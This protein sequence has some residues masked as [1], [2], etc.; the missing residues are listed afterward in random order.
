MPAQQKARGFTLIEIML[1][2][3]I[4]ALVVYAVY[5]SWM[6]VVRGKIAGEAA[7]LEVQRS[8]IAAQTIQEALWGTESFVADYQYYSFDAENNNDEASLSF[9][10]RLPPSFPRSGKFGRF[11]TRRVTFSVEP[12][13][14]GNKRLLLRQNLMLMDMDEDEK[15]HPVVLANDV[16]EFKLQFWAQRGTDW[17]DEWTQTNQLPQQVQITMQL[18]SRDPQRPP[19]A[20]ATYTVNIPAMA[21]QPNW[22]VPSLQGGRSGPSIPRPAPTPR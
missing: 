11:T 9:I 7:A 22:Q 3:A 19:L 14:N 17:Q 6:T 4:F 8:R 21:V 13:P 16:K 2:I 12:G 20:E 1:S 18:G 15:A 10:S 5:A